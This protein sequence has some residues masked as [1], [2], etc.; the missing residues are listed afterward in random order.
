MSITRIPVFLLS[1]LATNMAWSAGVPEPPYKYT[2]YGA[3]IN[4]VELRASPP[5]TAQMRVA[6]DEI[7]EGRTVCLVSFWTLGVTPKD[8]RITE[9]QYKDRM[10]LWIQVDRFNTAR[11]EVNCRLYP[12]L[13]KPLEAKCME[14]KWQTETDPLTME[15]L[16]DYHK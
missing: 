10:A 4:F 9:E 12:E 14:F 16:S 8:R 11:W 13:K 1:M 5:D 6:V 7:C 15:V 3:T 2:S